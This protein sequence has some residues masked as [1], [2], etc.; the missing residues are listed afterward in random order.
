MEA[1]K[2]LFPT[3]FSHMSDAALPEAADLARGAGA[4]L[5]IAHVEEPPMMYG[6]GAMYYGSPEPDR[7]TLRNM[8]N[9]VVPPTSD[10]PYEHHLLFGDPAAELV[11]L[12]ER[13][14]VDLIVLSTHG[15]TGL[16]RMLMGSVAER[17]VQRAPCPV[18]TLKPSPELTKA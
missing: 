4:T 16:M 7:D 13:E 1:R 17:V 3:D 6:A 14:N 5:L 15:R 12:A 2:I 18:L 8:L 9:E 11:A 10:V